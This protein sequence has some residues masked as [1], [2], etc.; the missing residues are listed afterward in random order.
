MM[1]WSVGSQRGE[2]MEDDMGVS[3]EAGLRFN[4]QMMI[5]RKSLAQRRLGHD[6]SAETVT[7]KL[8]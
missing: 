8:L 6:R 3:G 5:C 1:K 2:D 4:L 7:T